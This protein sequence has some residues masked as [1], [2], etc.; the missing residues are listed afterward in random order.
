MHSNDEI[1]A[2]Y[3]TPYEPGQM[4][5]I[6]IPH[7][8]P[9][10]SALPVIVS[11]A[12][13]EL[14]NNEIRTSTSSPILVG[15]RVYVTSETGYLVAV[16]AVKGNVLWKVKLGIEQ[17]NS[18]PL[19]ADGKIYAPILNDP[20]LSAAV[21]EESAAGGHDVSM[22]FQRQRDGGENGTGAGP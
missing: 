19:Y 2:I 8:T 7:V 4:I 15:D 14:W 9:T 5:G 1:I 13:V 3:G 11:R 10:N 12:E 18:S 6:K 21:G 20:G 22:E 17:R 16:D